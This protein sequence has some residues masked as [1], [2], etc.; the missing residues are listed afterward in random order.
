MRATASQTARSLGFSVPGNPA[1]GS[2]PWS[3]RVRWSILVAPLWMLPVYPVLRMAEDYHRNP[4][5]N[6]RLDDEDRALL[7]AVVAHEKLTRSD[8]IRRAIREYAARLGVKV[9][10]GRKGAR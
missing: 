9:P 8:I 10:K 7:Q 5:I 4:L 2:A 3:V 6:V 1:L